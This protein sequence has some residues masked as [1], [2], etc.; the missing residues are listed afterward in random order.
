M[1][2]DQIHRTFE[3]MEKWG[4]G[5]CKKLAAAWLHADQ[6]NRARIENAFPHLLEEYGPEG[7]FYVLE[8]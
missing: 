8:N 7:K 4:G 5:F 3:T 6:G 2:H 1:T